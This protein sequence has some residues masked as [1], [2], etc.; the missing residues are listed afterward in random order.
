MVS[1]PKIPELSCYAISMAE[2]PGQEIL[3]LRSQKAIIS[4]LSMLM[5]CITHGIWKC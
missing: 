2:Q 5:M 3:Q 4:H 1:V